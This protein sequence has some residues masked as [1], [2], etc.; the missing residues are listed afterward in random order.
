MSACGGGID[1][2]PLG[3]GFGP[4]RAGRYLFWDDVAGEPCQVLDQGCW[5][6]VVGGRPLL[7]G[8]GD[9]HALVAALDLQDQVVD[10]DLQGG[11]GGLVRLLNTA[12]QQGK[13]VVSKGG[14]GEAEQRRA[15]VAEAVVY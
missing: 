3:R 6:G 13:D 4:A 10:G 2:A 14:N 7:G 8:Q 1:V 5:I 9:E 12:L 15:W 11:V